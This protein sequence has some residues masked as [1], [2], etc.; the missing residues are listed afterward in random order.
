M[1]TVAASE[2]K[3]HCLSLLDDVSERHESFLILKRGVPVARVVP[4]LAE[5]GSPQGTLLG[6][7]IAEDDL[8]APPLAAE[9]WEAEWPP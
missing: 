6:T 8:L 5:A 4:V 3:T 2:F 9:E 1:K 7:V